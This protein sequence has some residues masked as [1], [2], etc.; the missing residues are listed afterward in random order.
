MSTASIGL[1][2]R[3]QQYLLDVS[4][5]EPE[6][7]A[8]L[9]Q[10]TLEM[11]EANMI[12]SPEQVQL[13]KLLCK[14]IGARKGLEIGTFTGYTSLWLTMA[15]PD[16]HLTCC[17]T[18]DTFTSVAREHWQ[19]ADVANRIDLQL[20]PAQATLERMLDEGF[21]GEYDFAYIDADK[22]GYRAYVEACLV[23]V[24]A[25]GLVMLDNVLWSGTVA[26]PS[27]QDEDTIALREVNAWI[28]E[29]AKGRYDLSLIP[30]GDG[31]TLIR[32]YL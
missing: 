21:E 22:T 8:R 32:K 27:D 31:L 18:S 1:D 4:L 9:R 16:L 29:R 15:M 28:H 25:G 17:D 5:H 30:I 11:P 3:L 14:T 19:A 23:L 20:G 10:R 6:A 7:C 24:R 2:D 12:S 26:D 13:I